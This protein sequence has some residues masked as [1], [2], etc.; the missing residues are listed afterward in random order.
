MIS[1]FKLLILIMS[2]CV[3]ATPAWAGRNSTS[4]FKTHPNLI[5]AEEQGDSI[6][7]ANKQVGIE[8][9]KS[10]SGFQI[11]RLYGIAGDQDFLTKAAGDIF[12]ITMT[13]DPKVLGK[14]ER[15]NIKRSAFNIIDQMEGDRFFIGSRAAKS[16]SWRREGNDAESV[17]HLEWKGID[18]KDDKEVMDVEVTITLRAGDSLSYW[19]INVYNRSRRY[20]IARLRL[21]LLNLAPIGNAEDNVLLYPEGRGCVR[22]NPFIRRNSEDFYPHQFVPFFQ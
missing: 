5:D 18:V 1:R 21:P 12:A 7:F 22:E 17:L 13:L 15:W 2:L 9:Q 10:D 4:F 14:D 16:V 20:G 11:G 6:L 8:I 19:R 3:I